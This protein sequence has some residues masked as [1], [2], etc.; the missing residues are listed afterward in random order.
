MDELIEDEL[1]EDGGACNR[2]AERA[3]QPDDAPQGGEVVPS[4]NVHN[5]TP[6]SQLSA[7]SMSTSTGAR[8]EPLDG[9]YVP[10]WRVKLLTIQWVM[11]PLCPFL[12]VI[13]P[14]SFGNGTDVS[15]FNLAVGVGL[16]VFQLAIGLLTHGATEQ[17]NP[18]RIS[19]SSAFFLVF[20]YVA[21]LIVAVLSPGTNA[22]AGYR[23]SMLELSLGLREGSLD[24]LYVGAVALLVFSALATLAS[25]GSDYLAAA[26]RPVT[27]QGGS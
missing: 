2:D 20:Y 8:A 13:V 19:S 18:R 27:A 26:R 10:T 1:I 6:S 17:E 25:A 21:V 16:F 12:L 5:T 11:W 7:S 3:D 14:G 4:V 22:M 9:D 15:L 24:A 23:P